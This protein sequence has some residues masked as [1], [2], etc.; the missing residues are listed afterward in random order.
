MFNVATGDYISVN[1][2]ARIVI[3]EL[4]LV[5]DAVILDHTPGDRGW[6]GDVPIVRL[7]TEKIRSTGWTCRH[8]T[9]EAIKISVKGLLE[10]E[11]RRRA[12]HDAQ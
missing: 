8:S 5:P 6:K 1:E 10:D 9:Q 11:N 12:T 7:S 3:E 4:D 2:I